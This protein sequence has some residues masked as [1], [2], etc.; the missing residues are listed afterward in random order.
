MLLDEPNLLEWTGYHRRGDLER[1]LRERGA[2]YWV[3]RNGR[4]CTTLSAVEVALG[5]RA[6][7]PPRAP[8]PTPAFR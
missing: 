2:R 8:A 7:S 1:F 3:G 4:I 5:V 6:D